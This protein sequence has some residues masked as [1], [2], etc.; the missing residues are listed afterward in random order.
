MVPDEIRAARRILGYSQQRL[1]D[2][3][4]VTLR[5]VCFWESGQKQMH[6]PTARLIRVL[7]KERL[8]EKAK[9]LT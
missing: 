1:A 3:L 6:E 9:A 5:A 8:A 4:G 2:S 7:V